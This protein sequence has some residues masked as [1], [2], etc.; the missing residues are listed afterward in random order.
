MENF[1]M[2]Y[3]HFKKLSLISSIR[4]K[5]EEVQDPNTAKE[6]LKSKLIE[7]GSQIKLGYID[8]QLARTTAI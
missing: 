8:F 5:T 7:I 4:N 2:L 1:G 6:A 3:V